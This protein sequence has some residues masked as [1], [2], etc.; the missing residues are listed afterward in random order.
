MER[1]F[2]NAEYEACRDRYCN[3][4]IILSRHA[5]SREICREC[6][7]PLLLPRPC[8]LAIKTM[9]PESP[10]ILYDLVRGQR[11]ELLHTSKVVAFSPDAKRVV[12][13]EENSS[14]MVADVWGGRY[15]CAQN[16]KAISRRHAVFL[17]SRCA[18]VAIGDPWDGS[19]EFNSIGLLDESAQIERIV[20]RLSG[21]LGF[22]LLGNALL[23]ELRNKGRLLLNPMTGQEL[24]LS[25]PRLD[26]RLAE[27]AHLYR[28]DGLYVTRSRK[29]D[30]LA[31]VDLDDRSRGV[32][33]IT[34][35]K[36]MHN[37][38][39]GSLVYD[40]D[41]SPDSRFLAWGDDRGVVTL[42][43]TEMSE[44]ARQKHTWLEACAL[45]S[46]IFNRA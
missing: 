25:D 32:T 43:N 12:C 2:V 14:S 27:A 19:I 35:S 21:C 39:Y 20:S 24:P 28:M 29:G 1:L 37:E 16:V 9:T 3:L 23:V 46:V 36:F 44:P 18:L 34:A 26:D 6:L 38:S 22:E 8:C 33:L 42:L 13:W 15:K 30:F 31:V 4:A 45:D 41:F 5:V 17:T 10:V 40:L 7:A 11:R